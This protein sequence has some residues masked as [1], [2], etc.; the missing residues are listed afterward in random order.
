MM[1]AARQSLMLETR[2][3]GV[4]VREREVA[5]DGKLYTAWY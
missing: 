5:P 1:E 2:I 4:E 3:H